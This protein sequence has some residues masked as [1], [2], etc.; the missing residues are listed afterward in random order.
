[1]SN[2]VSRSRWFMPV[3]CLLLGGVLFAAFAIGDDVGQ[4][5][6]SFGLLAALGALF[7]FGRRSETLQ[8]LGGPQ[9]DER[10]ASIDLRATAFAGAMAILVALGGFV[11]QVARGADAGPY[12]LVAAVAGVAYI[13]AV[14]YLRARG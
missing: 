9:K 7:A 12:V 2:D 8:G 11:V 4:G 3:F 1:M 13:A 10:W 5:A 6:I 14:A